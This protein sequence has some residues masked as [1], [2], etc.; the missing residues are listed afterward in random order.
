MNTVS[1]GIA[2]C[3]LLSEPLPVQLEVALG[4]HD[5]P[6]ELLAT[7]FE[8]L[9]VEGW[10]S[11][12]E[13]VLTVVCSRWRY[14]AVHIP[15]LWA[16]VSVVPDEPIQLIKTYLSRSCDKPLDLYL[17]MWLDEGIWKGP[18]GQ[19]LAV[20]MTHSHRWR[21]L[22]L[23]NMDARNLQSVLSRVSNLSSLPQLTHLTVH[24]NKPNGDFRRWFQ[25]ITAIS[26]PASSLRGLDIS[27]TKTRGLKSFHFDSLTH[28]ALRPTSPIICRLPDWTMFKRL[29]L[30]LRKLEY[31]ELKGD[32][33][34][35]D[36]DEVDFDIDVD[37]P[38][39]I[40]DVPTL[41]TLI[42]KT[43]TL[44]QFHFMLIGISSRHL[45]HLELFHPDDDD[46]EDEDG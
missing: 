43:D 34:R 30:S 28:L 8:E 11:H 19:R 22:S 39:G 16:A 13:R 32:I 23:T 2:G 17:E 9:F 1:D 15:A 10:P 36:F 20:L 45:H 4:I 7:I 24:N 3:T 6:N 38:F 5:I 25:F 41:R 14:V 44:E 37:C 46:D 33:V 29:L 40:V 27:I 21:R 31:L 35:F 18:L 12:S 42:L 26:T